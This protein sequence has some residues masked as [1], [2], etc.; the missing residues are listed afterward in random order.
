LRYVLKQADNLKKQLDEDE[1][2]AVWTPIK[3]YLCKSIGSS[4]LNKLYM[5]QAFHNGIDFAT[6]FQPG[7]LTTVNE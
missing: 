6:A 1:F 5:T 2:N 7:K 3:A 4:V